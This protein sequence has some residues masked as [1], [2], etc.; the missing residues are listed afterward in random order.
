MQKLIQ[1]NRK[2][3]SSKHKSLSIQFSL[4]GFS[5][6]VKDIPSKEVLVLSEYI[7]DKTLENPHLLQ[8]KVQQ[9]FETEKE[10]Q[11][12][13]SKV[14]AIHENQLATQIPEDFFDKDNL[15]K[16][17][18]YN[19]KTFSSDYITYDSLETLQAK[20][21]YIPY[22]NINNFL[23]QNFGEFEFK[24][25][26]TILLEQLIG[27]HSKTL[28][29]TMYVNVSNKNM[30]IVVFKN[31]QLTLY[32]SFKFNSKED[33]LYYILFVS[34]QLELNPINFQLFFLGNINEDFDTFKLAKEYVK[35]IDFLKS[36]YNFLQESEVFQPHSNY[37]LLS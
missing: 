30:D 12:E 2:E 36:K 22:V 19:I 4:D 10:L 6:C 29:N 14:T 3:I 34:E 16:Y 18:D 20:N 11:I 5:F 9:I 32:N 15:K 37:I 17:L 28:I 33:F 31:N 27:V 25:H 1:K 23:F 35:N 24:H 21:V 8:E 7:F 13:F 26:S